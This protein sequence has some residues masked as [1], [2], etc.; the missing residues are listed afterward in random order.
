M[1]VKSSKWLWFIFFL[2]SFVGYLRYTRQLTIAP[3]FV[4]DN[5][6]LIV[7]PGGG[8]LTDGTLTPHSIGRMEKAIEIYWLL[9]SKQ[10][11]PS[12]VT[13]SA[14]TP[15]KPNPIDQHSFPIYESSAGLRYLLSRKIPSDDLYEEKWSLDTIGNV[16]SPSFLP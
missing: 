10:L 2:G 1:V 6:I 12:V 13:L 14:G 7:I 5:N 8:L 9:K 3:D 11:H 15:H 16:S 4:D